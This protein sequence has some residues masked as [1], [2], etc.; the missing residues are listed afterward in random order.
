MFMFL[1]K[2]LI[3]L[4]RLKEAKKTNSQLIIKQDLGLQCQTPQDL[5]SQSTPKS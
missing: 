4:K 5:S 1:Y 3:I 2:V